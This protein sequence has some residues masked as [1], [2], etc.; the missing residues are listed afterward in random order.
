MGGNCRPGYTPR[1]YLHV[2]HYIVK[3]LEA[4]ADKGLI[5]NQA[6]KI[7]LNNQDKV[8]QPKNTLSA[9]VKKRC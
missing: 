7:S 4:R 2:I 1:L 3:N 8:E 6:W 5:Q 9:V